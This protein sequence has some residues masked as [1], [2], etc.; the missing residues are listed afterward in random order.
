MKSLKNCIFCLKTVF[1]YAPWNALCSAVCLFV[2]ASFAGFQVILLQRIVDSATAYVRGNGDAGIVIFW[3]ILFVGMLTLWV[4][5]QRIGLY[6]TQVVA[7]KLTEKMAPD[8][9]RRLAGLEYASFEKQGTQEVFQKMSGG[10]QNDIQGCF[11][12]ALTTAQAFF[13]MI[14]SMAVLFTVSPWIGLGVFVI[15]I[16]MMVCSYYAARRQ[17]AVTEELAD[18]RRRMEDLKSLL[19]DKHAMY[20]MKLFGAEDLFAEKWDYYSTKQAKITQREN[21]KVVMADIGSRL[22]NVMFLVFVVCTTSAGLLGGGLT[23]GQSAGVMNGMSGLGARLNDCSMHLIWL[24]ESAMRVDFYV[25]FTELEERKDLGEVTALPHYD[26]AFENV[27][28]RYPGMEREV[29]KNVTFYVKEGER[30]AFVGENGAGKSTIVKLLC[31]LYEPTAGN[32]TVGGVPVR[33]IAPKLRTR[34]LS[35]VFQDFQSYQFTLRENIAFGNLNALREDEKLMQALCHADAEGLCRDGGLDR[36]LGRLTEDGQD[37]SKGQWQRVAMARAFVSDAEYVVLDEPAAS[38]DPLAESH[39]YENFAKIFRER[40]T[41]MISHRLASAKMADRILVLDGGRI[42]QSGNHGELMG[43]QG[44]YR[45]MYLAQ[46]S[47]YED[48]NVSGGGPSLCGENLTCGKS[49][50]CGEN[51]TCG[52]E[53][54]GGENS[55]C[56]GEAPDGQVPCRKEGAV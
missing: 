50:L 25:K 11:C 2:P 26:I 40:G 33:E 53:V 16:P 56:G 22:L 43:K 46:S 34:V 39:M 5:L 49:S 29:L 55:L 9:T 23:L 54:S 17:T 19:V 15:G 3:G 45:T 10:P 20:E 4:S 21:R 13:S 51:P 28:F 30:I 18:T 8:I 24:L 52:E 42:V 41:I 6:Q 37:L 7:V 44:L 48:G 35:V 14:F 32:V 12:H 47:F 27:T 38:L 1:S 31:G 36:N